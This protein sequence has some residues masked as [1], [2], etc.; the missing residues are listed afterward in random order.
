MAL[1]TGSP[2]QSRHAAIAILVAAVVL[3]A[4]AVALPIWLLH[5]HYDAALAESADRLD[6]YNRLAAARPAIA[7]QL[8]AMR[9][10][11]PR[12]FF[13]RAGAPALSA[14]EAGEAV[15][16]IV[17]ASG[18]R[19]ITMQAPVTKDDGRYRQIIVN[20][21]MTAN[22]QA[23]RKILHAIETH[24]PYLFVDNLTVRSQ[25]PANFRP[26]PGAEPEMFLQF[27]VT[28]YTVAGAA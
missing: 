12:K 28:G 7:Q 26:T 11:E 8:E 24:V 14:A 6:R 27:D 22:V 4:A 17:D 16:A 23:M 10:K 25:V 1:K 13:L 2:Q 9:A 19:L 18:G 15:R 5:R 20:V 3:A 21:Q